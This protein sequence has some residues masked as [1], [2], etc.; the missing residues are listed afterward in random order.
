MRPEPGR[1][2]RPSLASVQS[3][4]LSLITGR[5]EGRGRSLTAAALVV[6]DARGSAEERIA[7]YAYMYRA[8][9]VEA[10]ESQF[11]RL[12]KH[13]GSADF[14]ALCAAYIDDHPSRHPSLRHLGQRLPGWLQAH[15]P[16]H[17]LLGGLAALEWART[18]VF[19]ALDEPLLTM[20]DVR[21][22]PA[23]QFGELPLR[24]M[25]AHRVVTVPAGTSALWDGLLVPEGGGSGAADRARPGAVEQPG[26]RDEQRNDKADEVLLVWREGTM[27]FH[28]PVQPAER[29]AL[30]LARVGTAF[31][32]ICDSLLQVND[33]EAATRQAF[34]WMAAWLADGLLTRAAV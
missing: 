11:P 9:M 30:A 31:G 28:R 26:E 5:D 10:L 14:A 13:L 12:A 33:E 21:A 20:D 23:E 2:Q 19:D 27:V 17:P 18:D 4:L 32:V 8:R 22:W 25:G 29:A 1:D 6:S 7:V 24:L 3:A 16:E 34:A 15:R